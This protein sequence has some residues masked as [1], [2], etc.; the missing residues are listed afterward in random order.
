MD[1]TNCTTSTFL[2]F[3]SFTFWEHFIHDRVMRDQ[4]PIPGNSRNIPWIWPDRHFSSHHV[5]RR[6]EKTR[7][8][9][10][11]TPAVPPYCSTSNIYRKY[12]CGWHNA[13]RCS[14]VCVLGHCTMIHK[15]SL[16]G[17][18]LYSRFDSLFWETLALWNVTL[19]Q[20]VSLCRERCVK[21]F[22]K[23]E[24]ATQKHLLATTS[25]CGVWK[26]TNHIQSEDRRLYVRQK[27]RK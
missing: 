2:K 6:W 12:V 25:P 3:H 22:Q 27:K 16:L 14:C 21:S 5:F 26:K 23:S 1:Y 24:L 8:P 15:L 9:Q 4:E 11:Q 17:E 7:D 20:F 13:T 18:L 10:D 19:C